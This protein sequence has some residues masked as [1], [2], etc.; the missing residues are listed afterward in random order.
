MS[1]LVVICSFVL[2]VPLIACDF[3]VREPSRFSDSDLQKLEAACRG[4]LRHVRNVSETDVLTAAEKNERAVI[5]DMRF[6]CETL[7]HER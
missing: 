5:A 7:A 6:Y 2:F 3:I 1:K 4:F